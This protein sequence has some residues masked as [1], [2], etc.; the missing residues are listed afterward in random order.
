MKG[1][2]CTNDTGISLPNLSYT[3]HAKIISICLK[4][5]TELLNRIKYKFQGMEE[6][7]KCLQCI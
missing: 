3:V 1:S 7:R 5:I 4:R 2:N 6:Y